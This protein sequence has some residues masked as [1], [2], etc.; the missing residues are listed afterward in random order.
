MRA[1]GRKAIGGAGTLIRVESMEIALGQLPTPSEPE[2]QSV[3]QPRNIFLVGF[4]ASGKS[5]VGRALSRLTGWPFADAD[6]EIVRRAE[7]PIDQ[8]FKDCGEPAFRELERAVIRDICADQG[9]IV[10]VGGGAFVDDGN[11]KALLEAGTVFCLNA[12]AETIHRRVLNGR[13]GAPVRPLLAGTDPLERIEQL[14]VER[15]PAYSE[16]HHTVQTDDL[17]QDQIADEIARAC[18]LVV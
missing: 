16:A 17:T 14:L 11:R 8:I 12:E 5:S 10:S 6:D 18:G 15:A 7:K 1:D 9:R 4:M 3:T 2:R 13:A